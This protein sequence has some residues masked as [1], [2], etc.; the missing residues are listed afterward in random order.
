MRRHARAVNGATVRADAAFTLQ[1]HMAQQPMGNDKQYSRGASARSTW[2]NTFTE[3]GSA[4]T[5]LK[6]FPFGAHWRS[7]STVASP[8]AGTCR[9]ATR[10]LLP[11]LIVTV[12]VW[13]M[14]QSRNRP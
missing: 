13:G 6:G 3:R 8:P 9:Y 10:P 1:D 12:S 2:K 14:P 4:A 7:I 11:A 5:S